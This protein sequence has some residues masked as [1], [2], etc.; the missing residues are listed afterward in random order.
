M[1]GL[2]QFRQLAAQ[3]AH[4]GHA[5][6]AQHLAPLARRAVAQSLQRL[7]AGQRQEGDQQEHLRHAVVARRQD[8]PLFRV[9]Q[10]ATGQQRRHCQQHAR[11][12]HISARLELG[13]HRPGAVQRGQ[14]AASGVGRAHAHRRGG[15]SAAAR[16]VRAQAGVWGRVFFFARRCSRPAWTALLSVL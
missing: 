13:G 16:T 3:R 8:E 11:A 14:H 15:V 6:Q 7:D 12:R 1:V 5:I 4:F 9:G 2:A 10:Q